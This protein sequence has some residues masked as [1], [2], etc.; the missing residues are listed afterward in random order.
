MV[1]VPT[2]TPLGGA[3]E[4]RVRALAGRR[5]H[6]SRV[7]AWPYQDDLDLR[8]A[9]RFQNWNGWG[10]GVVEACLA[11]YLA[12]R[13]GALRMT[14]IIR[15]SHFNVLSMQNAFLPPRFAALPPENWNEP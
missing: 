10:P 1:S 15:G 9:R 6:R 12:R 13:D 7:I 14:D 3:E 4:E 2:A 5:F 8:Q 11:P